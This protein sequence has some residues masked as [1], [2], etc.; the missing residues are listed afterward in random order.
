MKNS[1]LRSKNKSGKKMDNGEQ[2]IALTKLQTVRPDLFDTNVRCGG[3]A[4]GSGGVHCR[5]AV[6]VRKDPAGIYEKNNCQIVCCFIAGALNDGISREDMG[7][8]KA[9]VCGSGVLMRTCMNCS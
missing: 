3:R 4:C 9:C 7:P 6:L 8:S 5:N 1:S 2:M